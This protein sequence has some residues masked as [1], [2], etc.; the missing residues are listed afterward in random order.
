MKVVAIV[1]SSAESPII[2]EAVRIPTG[3]DQITKE[4]KYQKAGFQ[5]LFK[6]SNV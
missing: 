2:D 5:V 6:Y 4:C 3:S 1:R